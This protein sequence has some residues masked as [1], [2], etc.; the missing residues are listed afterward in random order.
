MLEDDASR[1][2]DVRQGTERDQAVAGADIQDNVAGVD[3]SVPQHPL[4]NGPQE[5]KRPSLLPTSAAVARS[6]ARLSTP[7]GWAPIPNLV[8]LLHRGAAG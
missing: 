6:E 5:L 8:T 4:S 2:P 1:L 7:A 3:A